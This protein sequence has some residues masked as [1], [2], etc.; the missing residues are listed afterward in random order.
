MPKT[1]V[2]RSRAA[3]LPPE[4]RRAAIIDAA[5]P[6]LIEHGEN[7]TTRQLAD[8]AGIAEG[9]IFRVFADKDELLSATLEAILDPTEFE[10]ALE[11]VDDALPFEEQLVEAA[12]MVHRRIAD[13]WE[14]V[15]RLGPAL[16]QQARRPMSDSEALIAL[17][18]RHA[19]RISVEPKTAARVLRALTLSATHPMLT[20]E[21]MTPAQVVDVV[22]HGIGVHG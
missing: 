7:V 10:L 6:L 1:V 8:A 11:A 21:P 5:R 3:A 19:D 12:T 15:A 17:F 13:V 16:R 18:A 2:T 22:L 14:V 4:E 20:P 9:T